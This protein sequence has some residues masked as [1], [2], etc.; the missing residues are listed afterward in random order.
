MNKWTT[1]EAGGIE[2]I[3][4]NPLSITLIAGG[5]LSIDPNDVPLNVLRGDELRIRI[6]RR[7]KLSI[8]VIS[9]ED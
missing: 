4:L 8:A 7:G 9:S 6:T 5:L 1:L 2:R 3:C